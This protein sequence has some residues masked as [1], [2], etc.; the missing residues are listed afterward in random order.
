MPV[1]LFGQAADME[2]LS[3]IATKH[4][5]PLIEDAAQALGSSFRGNVVGTLGDFGCFSF[6]PSKNLGGFGDAGLLTTMRDDLAERARMMRAHGSKPKYFHKYIGGNFRLDALQAALLNVKLPQLSRYTEA[7][8]EN[9]AEYARRFAE[10]TLPEGLLTLPREVHV[11]HVYNQYV[12]RSTRRDALREGLAKAGVSTE[13]YYPRPLH[14]QECFQSLGYKPGDLPE[15]E[16]ACAEV[17][18]LPV[19][20]ELTA[21]QKQHVVASVVRVLSH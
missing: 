6:F 9:V 21:A 1:H 17:L 20:G 8:R 5:L 4:G 7:R 13:I 2:E 18:A 16:R 11:G 15:T 14:L 12:V 19:Y 3:R 10:V